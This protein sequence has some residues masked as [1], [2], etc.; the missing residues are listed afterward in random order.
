MNRLSVAIIT[1]NAEKTIGDCLEAVNWADEIIIHDRISIDRTVE[2][3]QGHPNV[4]VYR[5]EMGSL[6]LAALL[7]ASLSITGKI[8]CPCS[9]ISSWICDGIPPQVGLMF[10]KDTSGSGLRVERLFDR[11]ASLR[12]S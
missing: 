3:C 12:I 4:K 7:T 10:Q 11:V 1:K 5:R 8:W 2:I 6:I 9:I